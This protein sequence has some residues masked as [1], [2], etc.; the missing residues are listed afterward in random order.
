MALN[1]IALSSKEAVF[2][3]VNIGKGIV[4]GPNVSS[5]EGI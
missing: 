5:C 3:M 1:I 4:P 2:D